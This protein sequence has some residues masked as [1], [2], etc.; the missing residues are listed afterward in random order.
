M[1]RTGHLHQLG[2]GYWSCADLQTT[3]E[4]VVINTSE[5]LKKKVTKCV[6]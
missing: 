5:D 6:S 1:S 2:S 3:L 4:R